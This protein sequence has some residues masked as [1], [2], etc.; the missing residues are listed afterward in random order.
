MQIAIAQMAESHHAT[1]RK[2]TLQ[3]R[4]GAADKI[5]NTG[6]GERNIMLDILAFG[7]LRV[8]DVFP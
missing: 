6:N 5:G 3:Q 7:R 4:I 2:I 8:R 1:A